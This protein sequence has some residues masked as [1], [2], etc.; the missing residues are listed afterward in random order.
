ME[1]CLDSIKILQNMSPQTEY[2]C[3]V[4]MI[5]II[6]RRITI[7]TER[8]MLISSAMIREKAEYTRDT[9]AKS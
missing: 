7:Y 2:T 9:F 6:V 4:N 5:V 3:R 1:L 8:K